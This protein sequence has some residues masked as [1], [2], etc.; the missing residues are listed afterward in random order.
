MTL[1]FWVVQMVMNFLVFGIVKDHQP[2]VS[3]CCIRTYL[4]WFYR[5]GL[6]PGFIQSIGMI[7]MVCPSDEW[8]EVVDLRV[9]EGKD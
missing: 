9:D 6:G 8:E 4:V 2:S 3:Q 7:T 5:T 1:N